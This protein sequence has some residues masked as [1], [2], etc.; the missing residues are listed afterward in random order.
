MNGPE[1]I[2]NI[3][4]FREA[5]MFSLKSELISPKVKTKSTHSTSLGAFVL[6][7]VGALPR[8]TI[9][10]G[11]IQANKMEVCLTRGDHL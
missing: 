10:V 7:H 2:N 4:D 3:N 5:H 6:I 1:T 11:N 8:A 9:A